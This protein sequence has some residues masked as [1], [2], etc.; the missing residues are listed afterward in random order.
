MEAEKLEVA[1]LPLLADDVAENDT[2]LPAASEQ[3]GR[4]KRVEQ[5]CKHGS[6]Q[7][8]AMCGSMHPR[9]MRPMDV[10]RVAPPSIKKCGL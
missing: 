6:W 4:A 7:M 1:A 10:K 9:P 5:W 3:E 2:G 8:C